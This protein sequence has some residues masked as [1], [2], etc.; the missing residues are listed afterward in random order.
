M[1]GNCSSK[2]YARSPQHVEV[3][4]KVIEAQVE[5]AAEIEFELDAAVSESKAVIEEND[6]QVNAEK[7]H[8]FLDELR[9]TFVRSGSRNLEANERVIELEAVENRFE[10]VK[11]TKSEQYA[12]DLQFGPIKPLTRAYQSE[13]EEDENGGNA[14]GF[15]DNVH[16]IS[17]VE[18]AKRLYS[19]KRST[20]GETDKLDSVKSL[21]HGGEA[22]VW[23]LRRKKNKEL[24]VCKAIPHG[25]NSISPPTEVRILQGLL[26]RHDRIIRLRDWFSGSLSTQLYFDYFSGGDLE[27]LSYQYYRHSARFPESFLWHIY[28]QLC[29]AVAFIHHGYDHRRQGKQ[30]EKWQ[31]IIHRDIKPANIFLRLPLN[32]PGKG[33]YPSIVLGDFGMASLHDTSDRIIGTPEFQPPEIPMASRKADVWAI[34]AIMHVLIHDGQAPIAPKPEF[35][36]GSKIDW[37]CEPIA[38]EPNLIDDK[39][40]RG[41]TFCVFG[42]LRDDPDYRWGVVD[43]LNTILHSQQRK[44]CTKEEWE[45]LADWAFSEDSRMKAK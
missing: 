36:A 42:A 14:D 19:L 38:R 22:K 30:P 43:L 7:S 9:K 23:L 16:L 10:P 24:V 17:G 2:R 21:T 5:A 8:K 11:L 35:Y 6:S 45:P 25:L 28:L 26:P 29:E 34:G 4:L 41:L 1:V 37:F 20:S 33:L 12:T 39:Y 15:E 18:L 32:Y 40:S 31:K 13:G 3:H 44:R 27:Q